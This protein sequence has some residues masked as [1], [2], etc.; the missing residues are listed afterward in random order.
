MS[1][2]PDL[3]AY[4]EGYDIILAFNKDIGTALSRVCETDE[5]ENG[6]ILSKAADI[7]RKEMLAMKNSFSGTFD[8]DCQLKS[9]PFSLLN[10]VT[11]I[12]KGTGIENFSKTDTEHCEIDKAALSI[13]QLVMFNSKEKSG[14]APKQSRRHNL[15]RETPLPVYLG[16][17]LHTKTRK[18]GLVDALFELGLCISYDRVMCISTDLGNNVCQYYH[19]TGAVCPPNLSKN[20]FTVAAVDNID[21]NPSSSTSKSSFHGTGISLFQNT[22]IE[23][24]SD[25]VPALPYQRTKQLSALPDNYTIVQPLALSKKL[26]TLP[27][28][29]G[30]IVTDAHRLKQASQKEF[31]FI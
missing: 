17:L 9:V 6:L 13:S 2:I 26:V 18:K 20:V 15:E 21:H 10:L 23:N 12:I 28:V 27:E 11:M 16:V 29:D 19:S 1:H 4:K 5:F 8:K 30:P 3:E 24:T 31:R 14:G 22:K 25:T 7:V